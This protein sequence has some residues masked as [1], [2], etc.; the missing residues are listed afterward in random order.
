MPAEGCPSCEVLRAYLRGTLPQEEAAVVAGHLGECPNCDSL[1]DTLESES[2]SLINQLRK[3]ASPDRY[4]QEP[5]CRE[6]VSQAADVA[7]KSASHDSTDT[8]SIFSGG[9]ETDL[10]RLGDYELLEELDH[11]GMGTVFRAMHVKLGRQ[12]A[13]KVLP[14]GRMTDERAVVRF[15]REM[16]A[17]GRLDHPNIVSATDAGEA[18]GVQF[19]AMELLDGFD[20]GQLVDLCGPLR[21]ADAC[22]L[23]ANAALGLQC[24][25]EHGLVHR[26]I[27]PS[28]VMLTV[29]GEVKVLDLGL[30]RFQFDQPADGREITAVGQPMG[31]ADYMAPEQV[32]D[33]HS[34]D[35]RADIYSLGCTFYKLLSGQ[36]PFGGEQYKS[37]IDKMMAHRKEAAPPINLFRRDLP[38]K[39]AHVLEQT[40][41]KDPDKRFSEPLELAGALAPFTVGSDLLGLMVTADEAR[42]VI[43]AEE[44]AAAASSVNKEDTGEFDEEDGSSSRGTGSRITGTGSRGNGSGTWKN[45]SATSKTLTGVQPAIGQFIEMDRARRRRKMLLVIL[46]SVVLT[47]VCILFG[48]VAWVNVS[49]NWGAGKRSIHQ[50]WTHLGPIDIPDAVARP[51]LERIDIPVQSMAKLTPGEPLSLT[52]LVAAPPTLEGCL[53]WTIETRGH[54][55]R[56]ESIVCSPDGSQTAT[57]TAEGVI[58]LWN[59]AD[60]SF[61]GVLVGY[62]GRVSALSWSPGGR[63]LAAGYSSEILRIW[64]VAAGQL[65]YELPARSAEQGSLAWSPDGR[66]LAYVSPHSQDERSDEIHL[67]QAATGEI[68][69]VLD[70]HEST[71]AALAFSPDGKLLAAGDQTRIKLWDPRSGDS[72]TDLKA[73]DHHQHPVSALAW[74]PSATMI[75][76]ACSA[77][78]GNHAVVVWD[79]ETGKPLGTLPAHPC[80]DKSLIWTGAGKILVSVGAFADRKVRFWDFS[81]GDYTARE[82]DGGAG[83]V[84]ASADQTT[85]VLLQQNADVRVFGTEFYN[86]VRQLPVH[87]GTP[88]GIAFSPDAKHLASGYDDGVV[89]LWDVDSGS[90]ITQ[91]K[92]NGRA[93]FTVWSPDG[94]AFAVMVSPQGQLSNASIAR[95]AVFDVETGTEKYGLRPKG[96]GRVDRIAWS[97]DGALI[98]GSGDEWIIW[99]NRFGKP[100]SSDPP[101]ASALGWSPNSTDLAVG[102]ESG[103]TI[104]NV[105]SSGE[106]HEMSASAPRAIAYSGDGNLLAATDGE[107]HTDVL[108]WNLDSPDDPLLH[109]LK[110]R[111]RSSILALGWRDD[112]T[113][114]SGSASEVCLWDLES[115]KL[116]SRKSVPVT[117]ISRDTQLIAAAGPSTI[118]VHRVDDGQLLCTMLALNNGQHAM[119]TP[120]GHW[121]GSPQAE[122]ELIHVVQTETG[123]QFFT[124]A[125]FADKYNWTN[126]P[127]LPEAKN[128]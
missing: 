102:W 43:E 99:D 32:R 21:V 49:S 22:E 86:E 27:K 29:D 80:G 88:G 75:A 114:V 103:V 3:P 110:G 20:L 36:P 84:A 72:V 2:D 85:F 95:A 35:I 52:A 48:Y 26:D 79:V 108:V 77:S 9:E 56:I 81:I 73:D 94:K 63:Y 24:A 125:E 76:S 18:E 15:E 123:Q 59:T 53:S 101:A 112:K 1:V 104:Y 126:A 74:S 115:G 16:K 8:A 28:N 127:N 120:Q 38:N 10:G 5:E 6:A 51:E 46:V 67:W 90:P 4:S 57:G 37:S 55:G 60:G 83:L 109:T 89:R 58:R 78:N 23:I 14:K 62:D 19:L 96:R 68:I 122:A 47:I 98:A 124:P 87:A 11:G 71:I 12:V 65:V 45:R 13:L 42:Q 100:Q 66:L 44:D 118:L 25:H 34:V 64:D 7:E 93:G 116:K 17:I 111:H 82:L 40:L 54:R 113:L 50:K 30:A 31:T 69:H 92:V 61:A 119:I 107:N 91:L 41:D 128:E 97:P 39:V 117:A 105:E 70:K 106:L 121:H 33:T